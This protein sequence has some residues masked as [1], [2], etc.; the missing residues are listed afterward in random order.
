MDG[1]VYNSGSIVIPRI[2]REST[3]ET[4]MIKCSV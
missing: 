4:S 3:D 2:V 1:W